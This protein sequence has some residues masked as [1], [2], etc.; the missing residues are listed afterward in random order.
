MEVNKSGNR[1]LLIK[2]T[3]NGFWYDMHHVLTQLYLAE[4]TNR[5]PVVYWG[6]NC[7]YS[8]DEE[9]NAFSQFFLPVS[10]YDIEDI[11]AQAATYFPAYWNKNNLKDESFL[12]AELYQL[13]K[14]INPEDIV[15]AE[16][17]VIVQSSFID[18]AK[19]MDWISKHPAYGYVSRY[20]FRNLLKKYIKLQPLVADEIDDFYF[21]HM[22]G[23]KLIAVHIRGSDK[24]TEV[25]HLQELNSRYADEIDRLL[26]MYPK[27]YI[28][29]MTDCS[30]ILEQYKRTFRNKIIHTE[31]NRV[32]QHGPG[33]HYQEYADRQRKGMEI[34][35]DTW[36]AARC[37]FF[38]GNGYSNVSQAIAELKDWNKAAIK[39]L[40]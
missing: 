3:G 10:R 32:P 17:D 16:E 15:E 9:T 4:I 38:I 7:I 18:D 35:M 14:S 37:D 5:L 39:L 23:R 24:A 2:S 40:Y 27:A 22:Q 6:K 19:L 20:L 26:Y 33:A 36:L 30:D 29:L 34:I 31:C 13:E 12:S 1:F 11:I 28:F 21:S 25:K 8:V